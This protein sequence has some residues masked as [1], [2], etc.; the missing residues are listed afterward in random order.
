VRPTGLGLKAIAFYAVLVAAFFAAP[1]MNL[2][3]LLLAFLSTLAVLAAWWGIRNLAAADGEVVEVR[4][5][6]AGAGN[7]LVLRL[8]APQRRRRLLACRAAVGASRAAVAALPVLDGE[9]VL[10]GR[11]PPLPR[12]IHPLERVELLSAYPFGLL[13]TS[14][15]LPPAPP[16]V[17][18]PA[19][20]DLGDAR[21]RRE[22]LAKLSGRLDA[23]GAGDSAPAGLRDYRQGDEPRLVHWRAS[24][25]RGDL[26]VREWDAEGQ[27]AIEVCLDLRAKPEELERALSMLAALALW[28]REHKEVLV[29][30]AQDHTATYGEDYAPWR[31][32]LAY[33]AAAAPLPA[34]APPPP[35]VA[36]GA[37]RLPASLDALEPAAAVPRRAPH[38]GRAAPPRRDA[39]QGAAAGAGPNAAASQRAAA[40]GALP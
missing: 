24:A 20:A 19:P 25:R 9:A 37:L 33:L 4:P 27:A 14:R 26:V 31:E 8:R 23:A 30:H 15:R 5:A 32:L 7:E 34:D 16:A 18:Y 21:T 2:F 39:P 10:G 22:V 3:F 40:P 28:G 17:V 12:G 36:P 13:C 35:A 6:P 38:P 1:Y 11:L 29:L